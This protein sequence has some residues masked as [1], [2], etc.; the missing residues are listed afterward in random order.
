MFHA[1]HS[2]LAI[3]GHVLVGAVFIVQAVGTLPRAR[4]ANHANKLRDKGFPVPS[5][6]LAIALGMMLIGGVMVILGV[7]PKIGGWALIIFTVIATLLY[8]NFWSIE[9]PVRRKEKRGPFFNNL[10]ILGGLLLVVS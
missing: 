10:A 9:D 2:V 6:T 3:L 7:Y 4:F 8:Q 5:I 1:T